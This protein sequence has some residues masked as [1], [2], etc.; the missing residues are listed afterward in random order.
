MGLTNKYLLN[1]RFFLYI[2]A[3]ITCE[4]LYSQFYPTILLNDSISIHDTI[5]VKINQDFRDTACCSF[6]LY[7]QCSEKEY[8]LYNNEKE[9]LIDENPYYIKKEELY[10]DLVFIPIDPG[11]STIVKLK[12]EKLFNLKNIDENNCSLDT[13][14]NGNFLLNVRCIIENHRFYNEYTTFKLYRKQ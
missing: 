11:S 6:S 3:T 5:F 9:L 4:N 1:L 12:G 14:Y 13:A 10:G 2:I 7:Y 8:H